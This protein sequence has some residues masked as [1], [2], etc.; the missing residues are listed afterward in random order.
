LHDHPRLALCP[1]LDSQLDSLATNTLHRSS[2]PF[3]IPTFHRFVDVPAR[4]V[5]DTD[6][7]KSQ[8]L[9][10]HNSEQSRG[11][12]PVERDNSPAQRQIAQLLPPLASATS[13]VHAPARH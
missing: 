8:P 4:L 5:L 1:Y 2:E 11:P 12:P 3:P 9:V 10:D 13:L 6:L 7:P